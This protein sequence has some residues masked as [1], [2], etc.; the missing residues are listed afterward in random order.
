MLNS[1]FVKKSFPDFTLQSF[2]RTL[3]QPSPPGQYS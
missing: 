3:M 1:D 2:L